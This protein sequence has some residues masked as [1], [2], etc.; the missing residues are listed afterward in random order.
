MLANR[1]P[2]VKEGFPVTLADYGV[3]DGPGSRYNAISAG[4]FRFA[5]ITGTIP[6][7]SESA[8]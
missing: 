1:A 3:F 2:P 8:M 5:G 7:C 6:A 4:R